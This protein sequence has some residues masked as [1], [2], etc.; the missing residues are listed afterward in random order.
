MFILM[1]LTWIY[2]VFGRCRWWRASSTASSRGHRHRGVRRLPHRLARA[3]ERRAVG[4]Q[5]RGLRR[6]FRFQGPFP[7]SCWR[8][9]SSRDR[10]ASGPVQVRHRRRAR[11]SRQ[12]LWRGDHRRRHAH[13][14][15]RALSPGRFIGFIA[16]GSRS[17][18][19]RWPGSTPCKAGKAP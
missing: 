18:P 10:R 13:A 16:A 2:L 4:D 15:A 7:T 11:R 5:R 19:A 14:R 12:E 6:H 1:A 17:G 8:P 9:A 3:Q